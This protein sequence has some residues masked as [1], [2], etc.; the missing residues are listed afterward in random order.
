MRLI[1]PN[2]FFRLMRINYVLAKH[3]LDDIIFATHLLRPFRFLIYF[4]PWNWFRSDRA[5]RGERIRKALA[6]CT[7]TKMAEVARS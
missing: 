5:P 3:G 1:G 4:L 6:N 7:D 2:Q